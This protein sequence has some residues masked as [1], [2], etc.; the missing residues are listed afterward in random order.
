[1]N[2]EQKGM[3]LGVVGV[4][5]FSVTLP[6][7]RIAV[8]GLD[9]VI[10]GLG[11]A[12]VAAAVAAAILTLTRQR[13]PERRHWRPLVIVAF[14]VVL[15]FPL[16]MTIAMQTVA[17]AHGGIV[18]GVLPLATTA[19]GAVFCGE[20]PSPGFWAVAVL[21]SA[22][23]V[24]FAIIEG[25]GALQAA[26][27]WLLAAA[28]SGGVGYAVGGE[29]SRSL[30]GWQVICWALVASL[31]FIVPP[32]LWVLPGVDWGAPATVWAGFVYVALF[33][34]LIG[35]FAWNRGLALGGVARVGQVQLLLLFM[36][37][38]FSAVLLGETIGPVMVLFAVAVVGTVAL[39][40]RMPVTR[41]AL[42]EDS[43]I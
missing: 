11:R 31:P 10:V 29:L 13:L 3:L 15:G 43:E 17:A 34:Q 18:L 25:A 40:R 4:T 37:L 14:G 36:T 20:R 30:G 2:D 16:F 7:T 6:A 8:T 42:K 28:A 39:G 27:L 22:L 24:G 38:A 32:V 26:D 12:V 1:M 9:P 41:R 33:S 23:V 19:A 21:G 35:F 5:I